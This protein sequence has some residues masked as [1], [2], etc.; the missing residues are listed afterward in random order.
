MRIFP[1]VRRARSLA[2]VCVLAAAA[3][4]PARGQAAATDSVFPVRIVDRPPTLP[5]GFKRIDAFAILAEQPGAP[6]SWTAVLGGGIG[7]TNFE[8]V[9]SS[10]RAAVAR[11]AFTP[12]P[13]LNGARSARL[14]IQPES[15]R[16]TAAEG[17]RGPRRVD[18][19]RAGP[20]HV[21]LIPS[22]AFALR[23]R[24]QRGNDVTL[25]SP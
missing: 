20:G 25:R 2:I 24:R 4:T 13:Y 11:R 14:T 9:G 21:G 18:D 8:I 23:G 1:H 5:H 17:W 19:G 12:L 3:S 10:S 15:G 6:E 22:A 16:R 7:L